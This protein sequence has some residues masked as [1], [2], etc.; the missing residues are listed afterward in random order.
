MH[1]VWPIFSNFKNITYFTINELLNMLF[2]RFQCFHFSS[3]NLNFAKNL[4]K[5]K[6]PFLRWIFN[7][8]P[9]FQYLTKSIDLL[10]L[11]SKMPAL[12]TKTC[13]LCLVLVNW[14]NAV[15]SIFLIWTC[16]ALD[17]W[18]PVNWPF[19]TLFFEKKTLHNYAEAF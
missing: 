12:F 10:T 14:R 18:T 2:C 17:Y 6:L 3:I 8:L 1:F 19:Q 13:F 7:V 11:D 9:E 4:T 16:C 15:Q 5:K